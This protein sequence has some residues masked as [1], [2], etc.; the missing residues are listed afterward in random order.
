MP[1]ASAFRE[2]TEYVPYPRGALLIP[3]EGAPGHLFV[4]L[5]SRCGDGGH[6]LVSISSVKDGIAFDETCV[7]DGG[8]HEFI[9]KKSFVYYR[10]AEM[11][12][13]VHIRRMVGKN[14]YK[15]K[16]DFDDPHF[17]R[18]CDGIP[19]SEFVK[20]WVVRYFAANPPPPPSA[21]IPPTRG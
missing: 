15:V 4:I 1:F 18:I 17:Q 8:E 21:D 7:F 13:A 12:P 11:K 6:L 5:T 2:M 20:P 16:N 10:F 14:F 9:N 19:V 3:C